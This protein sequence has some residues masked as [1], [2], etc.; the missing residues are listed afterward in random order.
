MERV[1]GSGTNAVASHQ[2]T[3]SAEST[4]SSTADDAYT[5]YVAKSLIQLEPR[6][7]RLEPPQHVISLQLN[8]ST[9]RWGW[10]WGHPPPWYDPVVIV[11]AL[12]GT[13]IAGMLF[14]Y[15]YRWGFAT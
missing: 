8:S 10:T 3:V 14:G 2:G 7:V 1:E 13:L 9:S 12:S 4:S 6:H 15:M 5:I 11:W